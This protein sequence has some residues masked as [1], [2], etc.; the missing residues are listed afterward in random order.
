M[1]SLCDIFPDDPSCAAPEPEP[2]PEPE[3]E[4]E[5]SE[6]E[7]EVVDEEGGEDGEGEGEEGGEE[8]AEVKVQEFGAAAEAAVKDWW[9]VRAVSGYAMINPMQ[10]HIA[11]GMGALSYGMSGLLE[12]IRYKS[13]SKFYDSFKMTGKTEYYK[14]A[15]QIRNFAALGIGLTLGITSILAAFGI[16][17]GINA[18]LWMWL[19]LAAWAA[20][21]AVSVIRFL[22]YDDAYS[23]KTDAVNGAI[24]KNIQS[25][26]KW[27]GIRDGIMDTTMSLTLFGAA[28]SLAFEYWNM[29]S[30]E[31]QA[32]AIGE[33][34]EA[35]SE[36][37]KS[38]AEMRETAGLN[39]KAGGEEAEEEE[40]E[41]EEGAEE[42]EEGEEGAEEGDEEAAD[43]ED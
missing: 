10:A 39:E 2:T 12:V 35:A 24:A 16:A 26:I 43:E 25:A 20:G 18:L 42:G 19:G 41:G 27:D 28:E 36:L 8:E 15:D 4:V 38:V 37:A 22:G 17:T 40:G 14:L 6:P 7:E 11:L 32:T 29:T 1:S 30:D 33:W 34:E 23:Q 21:G 13:D 5:E 9:F 3:P 31:D